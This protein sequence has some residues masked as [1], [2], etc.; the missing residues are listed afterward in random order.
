[1][2][3]QDY[4][5]FTGK[6]FG[7]KMNYRFMSKTQQILALYFST[8]FHIQKYLWTA[9]HVPSTGLEMDNS[10][11]NLCIHTP[12]Q[13]KPCLCKIPPHLSPLSQSLARSNVPVPQSASSLYTYSKG[14]FRH[15]GIAI[16][17]PYMT[18]WRGLLDPDRL[19]QRGITYAR[20]NWA[21]SVVF[22][23]RR[24]L[25]EILRINIFLFSL[26]I[27]VLTSICKWMQTNTVSLSL[28]VPQL[29]EFTAWLW[30]V[31]LLAP[32]SWS[33]D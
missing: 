24:A 21:E 25:Q 16:D 32:V 30:E 26:H 7:A 18:A 15:V 12:L 3:G 5:L 4:S 23:S 31:T 22:L 19:V 20:L 17:F 14:V 1:M 9:S 2:N 27:G 8:K 33:P 11:R 13:W 28:Y 6:C 10:S 29:C